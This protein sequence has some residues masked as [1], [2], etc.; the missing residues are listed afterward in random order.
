[1]LKEPVNHV[2]NSCCPSLNDQQL[3]LN[4]SP[5]GGVLDSAASVSPRIYPFN[6]ECLTEPIEL[7][8]RTSNIF[9]LQNHN[10]NHSLNKKN[11][12]THTKLNGGLNKTTTNGQRKNYSKEPL[13]KKK[14]LSILNSRQLD[15]DVVPPQSPTAPL[16]P[17]AVP[18]PPPPPTT[19][20]SL[21]IHKV[22]G[23]NNQ[24]NPGLVQIC[25]DKHTRE[26]QIVP[27]STVT[28]IGRRL[29]NGFYDD[30]LD[31]LP[32]RRN[33]GNAYIDPPARRYS[34]MGRA[35]Y[36]RNSEFKRNSIVQSRQR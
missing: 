28:G 3:Q 24:H 7:R 25:E 6:P 18:S 34:L 9:S 26:S 36:S 23:F 2:V 1:M 11:N 27:E 35:S 22:N 33:P 14:H 8:N 29:L 21:E 5:V 4:G 10:P 30:F 31:G 15:I 19:K 12:I 13:I 16:N 32:F 20:G 17:Y